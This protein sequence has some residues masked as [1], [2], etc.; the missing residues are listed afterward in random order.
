MVI[1]SSAGAGSATSTSELTA[2]AGQLVQQASRLL[3]QLLA[4]GRASLG[5]DQPLH[6]QYAVWLGR[7]LRGDLGVS[8][9]NSSPVT[10]E[11]RSP[12]PGHVAAFSFPVQPL[13]AS[14]NTCMQALMHSRPHACSTEE[15]WG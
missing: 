1:A 10:P 11:A 8:M 15:A 4:Q 6:V 12:V 14:A 9:L 5:L 7:A 2:D 3:Q 13:N